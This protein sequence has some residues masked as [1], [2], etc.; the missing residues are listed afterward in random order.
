MYKMLGTAVLLV[1][2]CPLIHAKTDTGSKLLELCKHNSEPKS[3]KTGDESLNLGYCIGYVG[4]LRMPS[5]WME[6][7]RSRSVCRKVVYKM[8]KRSQ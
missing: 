3:A 1:G 7:E 8:G 6:V 2:L 4:E 5:F